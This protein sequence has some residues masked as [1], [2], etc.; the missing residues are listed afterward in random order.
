MSDRVTAVQGEAE[1]LTQLGLPEAGF[2]L[3]LAHEVLSSVSSPAA[4]LA[5]IAAM[6]RPGG[7]ASVVI[8]NPVAVVLGR[9]LS[10]DVTGAL[11]AFRRPAPQAY[12]LAA[13]V[14]DCAEAGLVVESIQGIGA[15][16]ELVPGIDLERPGAARALAELEQAAAEASPYR[17]IA[18]R[19]HLVARRPD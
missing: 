8:A 5:Q 18:S 9:V 13:A 16:T 10:G 2:D 17:D 1:S 3:V 11:A 4:A 14:A 7:A 12:D 6:V 15:F 19:L